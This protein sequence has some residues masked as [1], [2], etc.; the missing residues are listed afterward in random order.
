[1]FVFK[2]VLLRMCCYRVCCYRLLDRSFKTKEVS[3]D[4]LKVATTNLSDDT[5]GFVF[6]KNKTCPIEIEKQSDECFFLERI[7]EKPH[8]ATVKCTRQVTLMI[9]NVQLC[10]AMRDPDFCEVGE[11]RN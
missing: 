5:R 4:V 3:L 1:M 11:L 6:S 8:M 2:G 10:K 9:S 7:C